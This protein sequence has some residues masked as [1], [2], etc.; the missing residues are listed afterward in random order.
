MRNAANALSTATTNPTTPSRQPENTTKSRKKR[1]AGRALNSHRPARA[2]ASVEVVGAPL[3]VLHDLRDVMRQIAVRAMDH[4]T[5]QGSDVVDRFEV[6]VHATA[7]VAAVAREQANMPIPTPRAVVKLAA[8]V[9]V[10]ELHPIRGVGRIPAGDDL[11]DLGAE[12]RTD[13]LVGV[14]RENPVVFGGL[15]SEV[16]LRG[17][18]RVSEGRAPAPRVPARE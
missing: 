12:L 16:P 6:F 3:G 15:D 4:R 8:E 11:S 13:P 10:S 2:T 18:R 1:H 9:V 14:D 7:D 5:C 17:D